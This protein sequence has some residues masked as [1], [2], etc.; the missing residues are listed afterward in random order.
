[1]VWVEGVRNAWQGGV[2]PVAVQGTPSQPVALS[3]ELVNEDVVENKIIASRLVFAISEKAGPLF[4]DLRLR[5]Q[6]LD[7]LSELLE[8]DIIRPGTV[9]MGLVEQWSLSG[10]PVQSWAL[11]SETV[12]R[13]LVLRLKDAYQAANATLVA[14]GVMPKIELSDRVRIPTRV[15]DTQGYGS[16]IGGLSNAHTQ[17]PASGVASAPSALAGST[18]SAAAPWMPSGVVN[19]PGHVAD[20]EYYDAG[21]STEPTPLVRARG[22]ANQVVNEILQ[23]LESNVVHAPA[24]GRR[25]DPSPTLVAALASQVRASYAS[26]VPSVPDVSPVGMVRVAN[27]MRLKSTELKASAETKNEKAT[28]EVVALMFQSILTEDRIPAGIRVWFSRLQGP[29]LKLALEDPDFLGTANHPARLLID[30]MG[31][32]VMGFDASGVDGA[33][34]ELEIKRIVQVIE[35][36][37]ESGSKVYKVVYEEFDTFLAKYLSESGSNKK[38]VGV[39][40]QVEQKETLVIQYTIEMRNLL[41]DISVR[42][43]IRD[44]LYKVWAE[45]VAV[46]T[47]RKG[48]QHE[49]TLLLKKVATDLLWAASAK[50]SREER[51]RLIQ[52]LPKILQRLRSGMTLLALEPQVQEVHIKAVSDIMTEAF[53]AKTQA[54]DPEKIQEMAERLSSLEDYLEE[55]N[56]GDLPLDAET[57]EVLLGEDAAAIEVVHT[58]GAKPTAAMLEWAE[59]MQIGS[60]FIL[61][62]QQRAMQ[63]QLA[64][65]SGRGHLNLFAAQSG[66]AYLIQAGRFASY[67]HAGLLVPQEEEPLTQRA[68]R[69]A[70]T[71][72]Q[73]NPE[74]LD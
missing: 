18:S 5:T 29:V 1:M 22:R 10:M 37:P 9:V 46:A 66:E 63:V 71:Q 54:V 61:E 8:S 28:I 39:A 49:D 26:N 13:L 74:L 40:Q 23:L 72:I 59:E 33:A 58:G 27:E 32:C 44:F 68:T 25:V 62:Y 11:V 6:R 70:L 60:W 12:Q 15:G 65:R 21:P 73:A 52:E 34:M 42:D 35:Q 4:D 30:R 55:D 24:S 67:L 50:P 51:T 17:F 16:T 56:A 47:L 45:V 7:G 38:V 57:L 41:K 69:D 43:G 64:W 53:H 48:G 20:R 31:S 14:R 2:H 19:T 36:Y 3:F